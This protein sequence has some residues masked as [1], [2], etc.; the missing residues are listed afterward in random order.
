[1]N[2]PAQVRRLTRFSLVTADAGRLAE[3]YMTALGCRRIAES[4]LKGE[5]FQRLMGVHSD[6]HSLILRLGEEI[7]E[8]LEF[9][10]PGQPYPAST[11]ASDVL[12]QHF[13]I[14]T[15][16][17]TGAWLAL[18]RTEGWTAITT[19]SPQRLPDSS[20]GVTAFK[21]RDPEGHPLELLSFPRDRTPQRWQ[22]SRDNRC[23]L[24]IDHSAISVDDSA[25]GTQ[26]YAGLGLETS[27]RS[28]NIGAEQD[29]LDG[30]QAVKVDVTAMSPPVPAPHVELLC[31]HAKQPACIFPR[32]NDVVATRLVFACDGLTEAQALIDPDGHHLTLLPSPTL[33][34]PV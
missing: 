34:R 1:M 12:F 31:Y 14:V 26:F 6:A 13:A 30:L 29:N 24:G 16:D 28:R 10:V 27:A 23:H 5:C 7:I 17:M 8:L 3:F 22:V 20:G 25:A 9:D 2:S 11:L 32:G 18:L 15:A 21:F 4:R 33:Q 19:G